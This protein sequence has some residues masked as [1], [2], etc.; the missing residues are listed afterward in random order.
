MTEA[1]GKKNPYFGRREFNLL[2]SDSL[3]HTASMGVFV[4]G[5]AELSKGIWTAW[6]QTIL[7][8]YILWT[9]SVHSSETYKDRF[10]QIQ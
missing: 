6:G 3:F 5:A 7:A 10:F 2:P 8:Q 9:S 1:R 4:R